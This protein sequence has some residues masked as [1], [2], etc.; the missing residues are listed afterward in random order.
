[1]LFIRFVFFIF[2]FISFNGRAISIFASASNS[3]LFKNLSRNQ[4][5]MIMTMMVVVIFLRESS[6]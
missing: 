3:N 5:T 4:Q 2:S 1:M 6:V